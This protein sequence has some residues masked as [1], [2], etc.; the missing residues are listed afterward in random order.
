MALWHIK[1]P[2]PK[3]LIDTNSQVFEAI[4]CG[5]CGHFSAHDGS[6]RDKAYSFNFYVTEQCLSLSLLTVGVSKI[7]MVLLMVISLFHMRLVRIIVS[8][9][10]ASC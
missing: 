5:R 8:G 10:K 1:R 7:C 6:M 2:S 4:N 9:V 3:R